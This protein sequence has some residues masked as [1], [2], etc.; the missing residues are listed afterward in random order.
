MLPWILCSILSVL[1]IL[2][3]IKLWILHKSMDQI[4]TEFRERLST[5]TNTLISI[6]SNDSHARHL[7]SELN[8]QLRLLRKQRRRYLNGDQELKDAVTNISHDLRT[9]LT[10]IFGYLDLLEKEE[11]SAAV[12]LYLSFITNRT[13]SLK[14]LT[15]ELF[16]YAIVLSTEN[17][18][19]LEMVSVHAILEESLAAF[20]PALMECNITPVISMPELPIKRYLDKA[21]TS[22]VFGNIL[23]NVLKYSDGDLQVQLCDNGDVVFTNTASDLDEIQAGKLLNRFFTVEAA[24]NATGLGLAISKTLVEQMKGELIVEYSDKRLSVLIRFAAP[25]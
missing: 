11:K 22:R 12:T 23:N 18:L 21:A 16:R 19:K 24:R 8:M 10:A 15:E 6:S 3:A 7:A 17:Q 5:D 25:N 20:Y 1:V 13:E 9:P 14:Q 4:C 2:L